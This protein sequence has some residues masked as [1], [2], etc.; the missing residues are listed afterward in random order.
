MAFFKGCGSGEWECN[1]GQCINDDY[2]CDTI[3]DC[4]DE[5]DE[6]D[7]QCG[8]GGKSIVKEE[9]QHINFH[10]NNIF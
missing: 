2:L 1:D 3:P 10:N 4:N 7:S 8:G 5:S 9:T 6:S